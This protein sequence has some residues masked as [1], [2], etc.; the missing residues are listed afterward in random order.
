MDWDRMHRTD[1]LLVL[2]VMLQGIHDAGWAYD[3]MDWPVDE[4]A[5][6]HEEDRKADVEAGM[7][8]RS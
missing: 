8:P 3:P 7:N 1:F 4:K 5:V 6:E 2:D